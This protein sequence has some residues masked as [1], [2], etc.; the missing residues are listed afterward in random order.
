MTVPPQD[1]AR[2]A[3]FHTAL[4]ASRR[5]LA[6][7][8]AGLSASSGLPTF[9][10]QGGLW[11]SHDAIEL[12]TPEAFLADPGLVWQFYSARRATALAAQPNPAHYALA[13]FAT[14]RGRNF[15][16]LTQNVDD[17][18]RRAHHPQAQLLSLH[19]SLFTLKCAG[20]FCDYVDP[21]NT[22][23]PL[24]P[25]L[26]TDNTDAPPRFIPSAELPHCPRCKT[27]LLRPGVVWFGEPLPSTVVTEADDFIAAAPVDLILVIGTSGTV[28]PAASYVSRVSAQGGKVA[29]FN[30]EIPD[31][32]LDRFA[33]PSLSEHSTTEDIYWSFK[34]DAAEWLPRALNPV[35]EQPLPP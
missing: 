19:G 21:Y 7:I 27:T 24:V 16:A 10:G 22:V 35:L 15:L 9:R 5:V 12:A 26:A 14:R 30:T 13:D 17:L 25:A 28:Y 6:L 1:A 4:R 31:E 23:H 32:D 3:S 11:R 33:V 2:L 20:F 18:S 34:G 29:V 8:G